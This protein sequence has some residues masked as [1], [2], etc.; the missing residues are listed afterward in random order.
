MATA[1]RKSVVKLAASP[2]EQGRQVIWD[3]LKSAHFAGEATTVRAISRRVSISPF[4]VRSYLTSLVAAGIASAQPQDVRG[5]PILYSLSG[6]DVSQRAPKL[7]IDG[8]PTVEQGGGRDRMWR[9][10]KMLKT[11]TARDLAVAA[12]LPGASVA[13]SEAIH[14]TQWL[15]KAGYLVVALPPKLGRASHKRSTFRLVR[16]TGPRAPM[17]TRARVVWDPNTN[18][19]A[20]V[21][22][23]RVQE[24]A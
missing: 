15:A 14:Y 8:S 2:W 20:Y 18:T 12:S 11:F 4:T 16:N 9:T 24:A 3:A 5:R 19:A 17:I 13:E 22:A 1:G 7:R 10:M 23:P 21:H 6:T